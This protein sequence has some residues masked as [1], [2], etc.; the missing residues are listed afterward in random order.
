M[1]RRFPWNAGKHHTTGGLSSNVSYLILYRY[2]STVT[3]V[4]YAVKP[5]L[6]IC[7]VWSWF[8]GG[9]STQTHKSTHGHTDSKAITLA[10]FDFFLE[11]RKTFI[12]NRFNRV[13]PEVAHLLKK[14]PRLRCTNVHSRAHNISLPNRILNQLTRLPI[15]LQSI[16]KL[17][18]HLSLDVPVFYQYVIIHISCVSSSVLHVQ[19]ITCLRGFIFLINSYNDYDC[20]GS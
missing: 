9:A 16:L 6:P 7:C 1:K 18:L 14:Y 4:L 11:L 3:C 5:C 10:C 13:E 19:R 15:S 17:F 8:G 2:T 20:Q 12:C